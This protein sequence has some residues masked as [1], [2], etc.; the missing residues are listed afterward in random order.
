MIASR[1]HVDVVQESF[2]RRRNVHKSFEFLPTEVKYN[3]TRS[4]P[5]LTRPSSAGW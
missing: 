5:L 4:S 3:R 1:L 2:A